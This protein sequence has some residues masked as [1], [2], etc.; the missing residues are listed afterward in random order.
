MCTAAAF[1]STTLH[2]FHYAHTLP[3]LLSN[4]PSMY[5]QLYINPR[6]YQPSHHSGQYNLQFISLSYTFLHVKFQ[7]SLYAVFLS[8]TNTFFY[9]SFSFDMSLVSFYNLNLLY[10]L[11]FEPTCII[12]VGHKQLHIYKYISSEVISFS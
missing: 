12:F 2:A 7:F 4:F 9:Q 8:I 10:L 6:P 11:T 1:A 5:S 3:P